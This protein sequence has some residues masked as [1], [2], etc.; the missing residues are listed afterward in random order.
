MQRL[1]IRNC[2]VTIC[3]FIGCDHLPISDKLAAI[4]SL[5]AEERH[6]SAYY[7]LESIDESQVTIAEDR[8]HYQLLKY[9]T[10]YLTGKQLPPD[11]VLDNAISFYQDK[12]NAKKLADCYYYKA[13]KLNDDKEYNQSILLFKE[14]EKYA[15]KTQNAQQLFK[16]SEA[17]S[18]INYNCGKYDLSLNY[19]KSAL[20]QA[21]KTNRKDWVAYSFYRMG[22][23]YLN[24]GFEDSALCNFDKTS[25]YIKYVREE[26]RPYFLSNL[27]LAYI[28]KNPE[29]SKKLLLESLSHKELI[30]ALEQ[31]AF[32][33]YNEGLQ[34]EAYSLWKRALVINSPTPKDNIIHNLL[35]YDIEHGKTNK[36][37]ERVNEI[38]TI[39]DSIIDK[40]RNDTIKDL[41]IR[42][43][44]EVSLNAAH[45]KLIKWQWY[46]GFA[47]GAC[48]I[49]SF[50][51]LLK[52]N[53]LK[54]ILNER[55][56]EIQNLIIQLNGKKTELENVNKKITLS[57]LEDD[58]NTTQMSQLLQDLQ[59]QK[60]NAERECLELNE[61]IKKWAGEEAEKVREGALLI[62]EVKENKSFR[63]WPEEQQKSLIAYYFAV[64]T[65]LAKQVRNKYKKLSTKEILYLILNDM[66]KGRPEM[67]TI[68]G[69]DE[70]T[71][72]S[73]KFRIK[74]KMK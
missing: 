14:A 29:K 25:P 46:L 20:D 32:I 58:K 67:S 10:S 17:I 6:D 37:C 5:V 72:R 71:L 3:I 47:V 16:I 45:E 15:N 2:F 43:D 70:N 44:H 9:Q 50:F 41:Q 12:Q 63:H 38:I 27:S 66:R 64:N 22:L 18:M 55:E 11:S 36:V 33:Y 34:D 73:Y 69:V 4:D 1:S 65:G 40:L 39:K 8:A 61:K 42:F 74:Q 23:A 19:G 51:W 60:E 49:L 7:L 62:N 52:R 53:K 56:I 35:E 30:A 13:F 48:L 21:V 59:R 28:D 54:R 31:L 57:T 24:L 26:D 68:M